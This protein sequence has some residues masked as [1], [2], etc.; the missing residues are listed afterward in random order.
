VSIIARTECHCRNITV[1]HEE[2]GGAN[3]QKAVNPEHR[4]DVVPDSQQRVGVAVQ[5][6]WQ[7]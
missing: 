1:Q 7:P 4:E 2:E 5:A 3:L 6:P